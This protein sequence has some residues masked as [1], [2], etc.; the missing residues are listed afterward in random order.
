MAHCPAGKIHRK[1]YTRKGYTRKTG[2]RVPGARVP[3][4]CVPDV[5]RPGKGLPGGEPGIGRLR[6][7]DLA[8][9]GYSL[10]KTARSRH[11]A[12]NAATRKHGALSVYRKLNALS[13]YTKRTSPSTSKKA[14]ADRNYVGEKHGF[15]HN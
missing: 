1:G 11:I 2:V 15:K 10:H 4:A 8:N 3:A 14:L 7:G 12:I 9:F 6:E 5:G 13:V